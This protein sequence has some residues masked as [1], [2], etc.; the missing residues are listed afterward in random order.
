MNIP[1]KE[2]EHDKEPLSKEAVH[3]M[4]KE[5]ERE[6]HSHENN[7]PDH[8]GEGHNPINHSQGGR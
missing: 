1:D 6:M 7:H 8:N 3:R 5:A 4:N 2:R